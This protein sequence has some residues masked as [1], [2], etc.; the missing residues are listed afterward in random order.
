[1]RAYRFAGSPTVKRRFLTVFRGYHHRP[2]IESGECYDMKNL[3]SDEY[4]LLSVRKA[5]Y[6]YADLDG[7]SMQDC[8]ALHSRSDHPLVCNRHGQIL[9][10]GHALEGLLITQDGSVP[11]SLLPKKIVS[12]GA[13]CVIFPDKVWFNAVKLANGE[14]LIPQTDYGLLENESRVKKGTQGYLG[15]ETVCFTPVYNTGTGF[16]PYQEGSITYSTEPPADPV[17]GAYWCNIGT[18]A[19]S[20]QTYDAAAACWRP[21]LTTYIKITAVDAQEQPLPIGS[22]FS[23]N[24]GI[25]ISGLDGRNAQAAETDVVRNHI[26]ALNGAHRLVDC[27][28]NA[29]V[30]E[31]M[32][33]AAR[34]LA[35]N[36]SIDED[37]V[38]SRKI[39]DMDFVVECANRLWGCKYGLVD[40]KRINEIYACRLGDFKNW[41]SFFGISTDSYTAS[42]GAEGAFTGAAV[43]EGCPLFF[44]EN[45]F[46][47][48]YPS[49][50]G[51]HKI[52]TVDQPGIQQGSWQSAAVIAGTLYYKGA[53]G[54]YAYTGSVAQC[55]SYK[56]GDSVYQNAVGGS[57]GTKYYL[58]MQDTDGR[59]WLFAYDTLRKLWHK[60]DNTR[61]L[62]T[63]EFDG[64]LYFEDGTNHAQKI[65]GVTSCNNVPWMAESGIIGLNLP[66][67]KR[68]GKL[69]LR[70][71]LA[72]GADM[73]ISVQYNSDGHWH[74]KLQLHGNHLKTVTVPIVPVRC[75]HLRLRL[76][77][78][79]GMRLYSISYLIEQGSDIP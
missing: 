34:V 42:R 36:A 12:M 9:C 69:N 73:R 43:L 66:E 11:E 35:S 45:S 5:R 1:M 44:R 28:E 67:Q 18:P 13:Y 53:D 61:F 14:E 4:P 32:L 56:L 39:P 17:N 63:A 48:V 77:G 7:A 21:V 79:G 3:T 40:G 30:I 10:H 78:T 72:V 24:D 41:N 25:F 38:F 26:H 33:G 8:V 58:S 15:G 68:I 29:L 57:C 6:A 22:G 74:E 2:V 75:D 65:G 59:F 49:A 60:E 19:A 62:F 52:I 46:E 23:P 54:V 50:V 31:G 16:V 20:L 76:E 51:A 37:I 47:K 64:A 70:F 55:I 71:A 27:S